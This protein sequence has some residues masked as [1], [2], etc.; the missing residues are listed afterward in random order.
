MRSGMPVVLKLHYLDRV[1]ANTLHMVQRELAIHAAL[2]HRHVL[3]LYAAFQVGG[4]PH[5]CGCLW[6]CGPPPS[7]A[8]LA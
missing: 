5:A 7:L 1:P 4:W 6:P 8:R 2:R 3:P